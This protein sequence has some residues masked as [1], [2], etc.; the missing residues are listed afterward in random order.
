MPWLACPRCL[1]VKSDRADNLLET[2]G[3]G[4]HWAARQRN[5]SNKTQRLHDELNHVD[6]KPLVDTFWQMKAQ[7]YEMEPPRSNENLPTIPSFYKPLKYFG[8]ILSLLK[9]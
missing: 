6:V 4:E 9:N 8:G 2:Y 7:L 1:K 5:N 3:H